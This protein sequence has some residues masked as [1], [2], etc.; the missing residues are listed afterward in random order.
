M[1]HSNQFNLEV[2]PCRLEHF[3]ASPE[4]N[5][6][7]SLKCSSFASLSLVEWKVQMLNSVCVCLVGGQAKRWS[8]LCDEDDPEQLLRQF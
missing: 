5:I 3:H 8:S 4:T 6:L 1:L 7:I 2:A